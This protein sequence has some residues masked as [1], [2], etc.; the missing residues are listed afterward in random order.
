MEA[1]F[2]NW[3]AICETKARYCRFVDAKDWANYA[4]CFTEDLV[5]DV[6]ALGGRRVEGRD[7]AL[8]FIRSSVEGA[9]TAHHVHNPEMTFD[10]AGAD[11]IWAMQDRVQWIDSPCPYPGYGG[12]VG[13]GQYHERYIK[14]ADGRWRIASV[15]ITNFVFDTTPPAEG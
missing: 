9:K 6:T 2:E 13:Y 3:R 10:R 11:V 12:H 5:F 15:R 7:A 4:Q 8:T 14:G 1:T